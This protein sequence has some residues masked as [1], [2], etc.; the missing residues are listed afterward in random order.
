MLNN[1]QGKKYKYLLF[2]LDGT[3]TDSKPG[4]TRCVK[5]ALNHFGI[6]VANTEDLQAFIGPPLRDSFRNLY[7]FSDSQAEEAVAVFN[8]QY[9]TSGLYENAVYDGIPEMLSA[10]TDCGYKLAIATSKPASLA[11]RVLEH[12]DL[13]HWFCALCGGLPNGPLS[14]KSGVITHVIKELDIESPHTKALMIGDRKHDMI[15][16]RDNG[17]SALGAL[18][19]YGS[20]EELMTAGATMLAATPTQVVELLQQNR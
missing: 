4:I 1:I 9:D 18:W 15:G 20:R 2:D 7:G 10:L 3:L 11:E 8:A 16:A 19:G 13:R 17:I 6:E 5:T 12:F 14:T